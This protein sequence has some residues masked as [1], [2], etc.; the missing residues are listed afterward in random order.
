M[1][2]AYDWIAYDPDFLPLK[3]SPRSRFPAFK[4]FLRDQN[5]HDYPRRQRPAE[6]EEDTDGD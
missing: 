1:E 4:K 3:N 2:R 6:T 5:R